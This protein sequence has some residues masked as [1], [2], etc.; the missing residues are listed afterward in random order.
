M[1]VLVITNWKAGDKPLDAQ[2]TRVLIEGRNGGLLAWL[3][4][5]VQIEPLTRLRITSE[6]AELER[7][8]LSGKEHHFVPLENICHCYYGYHKPWR[9]ALVLLIVSWWLFTVLF[10]LV[11]AIV[12]R[13]PRAFS[14]TSTL[15]GG[16]LAAIVALGISVAYYL[17]TKSF[18]LAFVT[19][20]GHSYQVIFRRS[21]IENQ[22]IDAEEAA[23]VTE[24]LDY[25]C[26]TRRNPPV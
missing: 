20:S 13:D 16:V 22:K 7:A 19:E 11:A 21:I 10:P 12:S 17:L 2:G 1:A 18:L 6:R 14:G 3:L 23:Y 24:I 9:K 25:L 8:S 15:L 4:H 5:L 26:D